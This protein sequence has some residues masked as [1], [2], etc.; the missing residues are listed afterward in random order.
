MTNNSSSWWETR[1]LQKDGGVVI[2]DERKQLGD[3]KLF[4]NKKII[5]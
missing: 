3:T 2:H 5:I 1:D 4:L